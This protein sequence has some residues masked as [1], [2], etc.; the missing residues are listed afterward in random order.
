MAQRQ[1]DQQGLANQG[2]PLGDASEHSRGKKVTTDPESY[3]NPHVESAGPVASDSLAAES[4]RAGGAFASNRN[5]APQSVS[6]SA[7]TFANTDTS[8]A[9][10]LDPAPDAAEREAKSAWQE[11]PD[12]ARGPAGLRYPEGAGDAKFP[13][14][15]SQHGYVGGSREAQQEIGAGSG[16]Y[17]ASGMRGGAAPGGTGD[18][19]NSAGVEAKA[20]ADLGAAPGYVSSV[21]S[22]PRQ[23]GKPH[24]K[25]VKDVTE[26]GFEGEEGKNVSFDAEI[27]SKDDPG[28]A[29]TEQ[30]QTKAQTSA[31][32]KGPRQHKVTG[33]GQYDVLDTDQTL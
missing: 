22:E 20:K 30:L 32:D 17:V 15:H 21:V 33:D 23:T 12:E 1:P 19:D 28:R 29:A 6:G 11:V 2:Q 24:G 16:E 31:G 3:Q 8:G 13:G 14:V 27:G 9:T 7:S 26:S 18:V 5:A 25:N 10:T 4:T